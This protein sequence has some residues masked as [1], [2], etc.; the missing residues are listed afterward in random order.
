MSGAAGRRCQAEYISRRRQ[1]AAGLHACRPWPCWLGRTSSSRAAAPC[2]PPP[3][4]TAAA[5]SSPGRRPCAARS[6]VGSPAGEQWREGGREGSGGWGGGRCEGVERS[7]LRSAACANLSA[8]ARWLQRW[9]PGGPAG[10]LPL[11][12]RCAGTHQRPLHVANAIDLSVPG[13]VPAGGESGGLRPWGGC[14]SRMLRAA[15]GA[16]TP[17][18]KCSGACAPSRLPPA[19][20][21]PK[22]W[23]SGRSARMRASTRSDPEALARFGW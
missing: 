19:H 9:P 4:Q 23:A 14:H 1:A 2:R 7:A 5:A 13:E 15:A 17:F 16:A 11:P 18:C 22:T 8:H 12:Q 3:C 6:R 21:W 10:P 20:V